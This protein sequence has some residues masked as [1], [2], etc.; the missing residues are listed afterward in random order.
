MKRVFYLLGFVALTA[1]VGG[2]T[3]YLVTKD[4]S[5]TVHTEFVS[6]NVG[7]HFTNY[8]KEK[9]PDLTYAAEN[10]VQAVVNIEKSQE[11]KQRYGGRGGGGGYDPF[12]EFFGGPGGPDGGQ[13]PER[14][15]EVR[16]GGSGVIISS[17]GYIVSNNHV[18]ENASKLKVT[19]NDDRVFEAKLIGT[20]PTTDIALLKIDAE[21]LPTLS[22]GDS[23]KLRLGEWVLAIG[24]PFDLRST[25]TAGII[26]AKARNLD[27]IP[28]QYRVES[29]IQTDA[30][31]NPGNSGGALVNTQGELVGI[32]TVIKSPTGSF[33]GYSFAVPVS[34]VKKVVV[35]LKE[36]GLVQRALLGIGFREVNTAFIEEFGSK[37]GITEIGGV[38]VMAVDPD[39]AAKAAG[40]KEGDVITAIDGVKIDKSGAVTEQIAKHRPNDKVVVSLK[41]GK[42]VKQIEVVLRNKAGKAELLEKEYVDVAESLGGRY[43]EVSDK[44]KKA[45]KIEGGVKVL[46][47]EK[48]G[49]LK[50][51]NV[52][53]NYII[54]GI[55]GK[56]VKSVSDLAKIT[57]KVKLIEGIYPNGAGM[58]YSIV[59]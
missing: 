20:D 1:G 15:Q 59:E 22:F 29:F 53:P 51:A 5:S 42:D 3:A 11:V 7:A 38:C 19:L 43:G 14:S 4:K 31:V 28:S 56:A 39:G 34:I 8:E 47:I 55:N 6:G 23:E 32:N 57:T 27:V 9:Y 54:T 10:A 52:R 58:S 35:D 44:E 21:N 25:V 45:L 40:I 13:Q 12:Y 50:Q 37:Y 46:A 16:S 26:S 17:D 30:A 18:V 41:R 2:T 24:S 33:A 36:Y 48:E 49:I